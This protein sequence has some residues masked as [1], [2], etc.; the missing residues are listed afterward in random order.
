MGLRALNK[1]FL[2]R[3][4]SFSYFDGFN[5]NKTQ[6]IISDKSRKYKVSPPI[7]VMDGRE[8]EFT[9]HIKYL[10]MTIHSRLS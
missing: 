6:A 10:A 8:L 4:L 5:P 7:I 1:I 9:D 3:L 2:Y